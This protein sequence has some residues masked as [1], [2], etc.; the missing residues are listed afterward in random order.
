MCKP[1]QGGRAAFD[2]PANARNKGRPGRCPLTHKK[3]TRWELSLG[4]DR[5]T[6][7]A[8]PLPP[9]HGTASD[10]SAPFSASTCHATSRAR[11]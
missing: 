2:P 3:H 10:A 7:G 1:E 5:P 6:G 11:C 8:T 4:C 9:C